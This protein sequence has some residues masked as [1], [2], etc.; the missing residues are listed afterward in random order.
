MRVQYI[1]N[2]H[3]SKQLQIRRVLPHWHEGVEAVQKVHLLEVT[4][5]RFQEGLLD[6]QVYG[7]HDRVKGEETLGDERGKSLKSLNID[8]FCM[9]NI[10]NKKKKKT[11]VKLESSSNLTGCS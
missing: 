5:L 4:L 2:L 9:K 1:K 10:K 3:N 11:N 7:L 6:A 8:S